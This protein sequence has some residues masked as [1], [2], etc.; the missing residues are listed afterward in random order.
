MRSSGK[1]IIFFACIVCGYASQNPLPD[2]VTPLYANYDGLD[3]MSDAPWVI[4]KTI[5]SNDFLLTDAE[6]PD[7]TN[8][9]IQ[10]QKNTVRCK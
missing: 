9:P 2:S 1:A 5:A 4:N 8:D 3:L 7:L 6:N 10:M